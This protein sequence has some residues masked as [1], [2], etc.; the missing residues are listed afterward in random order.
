MLLSAYTK[1]GWPQSPARASSDSNPGACTSHAKEL[2]HYAARRGTKCSPTFKL[3]PLA[4]LS[5]DRSAGNLGCW[6]M[7][8]CELSCKHLERRSL[9]VSVIGPRVVV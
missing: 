1:V 5:F 7:K 8:V 2:Q 3:H 6:K 4:G 9:S